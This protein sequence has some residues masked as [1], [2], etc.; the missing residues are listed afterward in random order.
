M[1]D[2]HLL[3]KVADSWS[4]LYLE[5]G[6]IEQED[7]TIAY[8][9][10][11]GRVSIPCASLMLL[12]L[13]PG[14]TITHA[15][16]R[17]LTECG[18]LVQWAGQ[19]GVRLYAHGLGETLSSARL[20]AQVRYWAD[21]NLHLAVVRRMYQFRFTDHLPDEFTLEQIRGKE[22]VRV[23]EAYAAASRA[24]GVAWTGRVYQRQEWRSADP[25]NRALSAANSCLYGVCHSAILAAGYSPALGFVHTGKMLSFVYDVADLYKTE[26]T[27]PT[28]F[29]VAAE[30]SGD[31]ES[32]VR[33][34]LRDQFA[35][36]RLLRRIVEDLGRLFGN[37]GE[38]LAFDG[39]PALPGSLWAMGDSVPGG[40]N[41]AADQS[42][43]SDGCD[44]PGT[45]TD[46]R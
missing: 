6:N 19:D 45:G 37:E 2:F 25:I 12:V 9:T 46:E 36:T 20:L 7:K 29:A 3:P 44:D 30:G 22:G 18:C 27:I 4:Y 15:A 35:A 42:G 24:S 26:T 11:A 8:C 13:G 5:H 38:D 31:I 34:R 40:V 16:I 39:D 33:R 28:A 32:R 23:R 41:W 10:E 14:T 17:S 21:P 43:R 1:Q